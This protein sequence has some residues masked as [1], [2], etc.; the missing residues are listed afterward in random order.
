MM[1][2]YVFGATGGGGET[3]TCAFEDCPEFASGAG[4]FGAI[5]LMEDLA[6][7]HELHAMIKL[8]M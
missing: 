3:K 4:E 2:P 5:R 6:P 8:L 1:N 7:P